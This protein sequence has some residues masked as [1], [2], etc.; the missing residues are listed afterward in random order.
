[1]GYMFTVKHIGN[2][3]PSNIV[4]LK[5]TDSFLPI[6]SVAK[7]SECLYLFVHNL[8]EY[9]LKQPFKSQLHF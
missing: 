7:Y 5:V 8:A 2:N 4:I 9:I 1:M 6:Y 3:K